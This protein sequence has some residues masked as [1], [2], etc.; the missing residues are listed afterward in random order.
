MQTDITQSF[1]TGVVTNVVVVLFRVAWVLSGV[2][3]YQANMELR[4]VGNFSPRVARMLSFRSLEHSYFP[5]ALAAVTFP[6]AA[7][8]LTNRRRSLHPC[9][10]R[11]ANVYF[12][13]CSF[14]PHE[15]G[16]T[17]LQMTASHSVRYILVP[18][19]YAIFFIFQKIMLCILKIFLLKI[20][21][22]FS[23]SLEGNN[24]ALRVVLKLVKT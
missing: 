15:R 4:F 21:A 20:V 12:N 7:L 17:S 1:P 19:F 24:Q 8:P 13:S 2:E 14:T 10:P 5:Y 3:G 23:V 6:E 9:L 22:M 16:N 18:P 11:S